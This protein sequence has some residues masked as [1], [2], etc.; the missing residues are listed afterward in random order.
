MRIWLT[1]PEVSLRPRLR[2]ALLAKS[3]GRE[4]G[5]RSPSTKSAADD[6]VC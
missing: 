5:V 3:Y 6:R 1:S 4:N 2:F